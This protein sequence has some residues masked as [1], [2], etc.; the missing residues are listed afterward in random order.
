MNP[1]VRLFPKYAI[2]STPE[3]DF[4]TH[5]ELGKVVTRISRKLVSKNETLREA[6]HRINILEKKIAEL[7]AALKH[8]QNLS[9]RQERSVRYRR[10]KP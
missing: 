6:A 8:E 2:I 7:Q 5:R 3:H 10:R 9:I 1:L 4:E